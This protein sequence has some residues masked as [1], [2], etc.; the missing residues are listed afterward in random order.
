M[1]STSPF[2][3]WYNI[4]NIVG[5]ARVTGSS[6]VSSIPL[7]LSVEGVRVEKHIVVML[8]SNVRGRLTGIP[9][10]RRRWICNAYTEVWR[11]L[12]HEQSWLMVKCGAVA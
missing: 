7:L 3:L 4:V 11:V 10:G 12:A 1:Q 2:Q 6:P 9:V 8:W 5:V